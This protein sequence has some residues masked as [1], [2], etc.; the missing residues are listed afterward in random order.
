MPY[1]VQILHPAYIMRGQWA[2]DPLQP[3][4]LARAREIAEAGH[5]T[6]PDP[7][8]LPPNANIFPSLRQLE[9]FSATTD[10]TDP[11]HLD[12]EAAGDHLICCGI[13]RASDESYVCVRF[14]GQGGDLWEPADLPARAEW[15]FNF[16]SGPWP[17]IFHN[18]QAYDVPQL[19]R[20]GFVVNGF[21]DDTLLLAHLTYAEMKKALAFLALTYCGIPNWKTLVSPEDEEKEES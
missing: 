7:T 4:Y 17:K 9:E 8:T 1:V 15:L 18:G 5:Y 11:C 19:E 2:Q 12:I 21:T 10:P 14:R 6:P 13:L 3:T 16:L 20:L